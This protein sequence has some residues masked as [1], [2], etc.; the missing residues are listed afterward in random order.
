M[1]LR[2]G[3]ETLIERIADM[4]KKGAATTGIAWLPY[5]TGRLKPLLQGCEG[6]G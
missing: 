3:L 2:R 5:E 1:Q 6:D 4:V